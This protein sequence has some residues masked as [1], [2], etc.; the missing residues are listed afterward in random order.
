MHSTTGS[1]TPSSRSGFEVLDP[2]TPQLERD[3]FPPADTQ[4]STSE[5]VA[6]VGLS[7]RTAGG[8]NTP[9]K[10]WDFLL[11]KKNASGEVPA[12]RWEPWRQQD[13]R[14]GK[15][16]DN[17]IRKGYFLENLENFDAAFFGISPKEAELM[18]PHQ[19]LALELAWE[20]LENA[21]VDPKKLAG[22]DTAV[23]MGV[24]S[25]DY[26]RMLMEDLPTIEAW[27]GIG[28]AYHGIPNRI[29]YHLGLQGPSTAVDAA[30]ASSLIAIH[31]ARQAI[32]SGESTVAICGGVNVICA[33]GLTHML[34]KAGALT[35]EGVCRSF[36]DAACGYARGEGGAVVV[37]KR[38]SAAIEDND[39]ILAVMKSSASAQDGKTK[40]IMAP[41]SKAQE[42]V[43]RQ[44]LARAGNIDP[45]T[46]DYVEA[47]A[48]STSLGDPTEI[49]AIAQ[50]YGAGR[51]S[52]SPCYVGSIKPNVGHLEAAAGAIGFVKAVLSVQKGVVAPQTLLNKLNTKIDWASSGLE[53]AREQKAWPERD[54][55]R[56]AV[57]CYGYGGSVCHAILEQAPTRSHRLGRLQQIPSTGLS[58][59]SD[60]AVVLTLSAMQEKR[61]PAHAASLAH[62]LSSRDGMSEDLRAVARTLSQ[63]R[64]AHD[65]R[66]SFVIPINGHEDAVRSL[67]DFA[68]SRPDPWT[69]SNRVLDNAMQ[70][71]VVWVYSGHGAQWPNMGMELL[72]N[73]T[74]YYTLSSLDPIFQKEADFS[75]IEALETGNLGDSARVQILTYAVQIGLTALLKS[76]GVRP[77]AIIGHSVGEIAAAVAAGCLT[78]HE[79]AIVV[80]RRAKL[81]ARVQGQGA[82]ALVTS[83]FETAAQQLVGRVDI[84]AAIK[85]SPS[86]CV[87]S[88]TTQAVERYVE[89]LQKQSIKSWRVQTDIGFHSPMLG[90][91]VSALQQSLGQDINPQPAILPIYSTSASDARTTSLRGIEYW[92]K[93][94]VDPVWLVDA[95]DAAVEDGFRVFMEISTHP[96]VSHSI[97]ETLSARSIDECATFGIMKKDVSAEHSILNAIGQLH[98]LGG[99]VDFGALH[100]Q[101][102]WSTRV[103]NTPWV[104]KPYWKTISMGSRSAAQQ[105]DVDTHTVLGGVMEIAGSNTKVWTTTLDGSTKPYPLTHP[106]DGTEII[107]A[108]VYCNTFQ[109]A[110]GA[111]ILNNLE[112]RVPTPMA[113][114]KRE[115][116]IVVE[117]DEVR[118]A[119][120]LKEEITGT[121][122]VDHAWVQHSAARFTDTDMSSHQQTLSISAIRM[123][124]G[125]QL[126]NSFAWD[127]LQSIGVSGIAF[128]WAVLEHFGNDKEM[129]VKMDMDPSS[130]TLTWDAQSWAPF[131]DAA[132]SVGSSIFFKSV[133][134]RI[135]SGIDQIFFLSTD[136]PPK[137]GY[138]FIE[139]SSEG[140]NLKANISVLSEDGLLLTKI[141]GMRFSDV[142]AVSDKSKGVD[143]LVH[144]LTWVPPKFSETP[145]VMN[146]VVVVSAESPILDNYVNTLEI[147]AKRVVTVPSSANLAEPEI[148]TLLE[149]KNAIAIYL[150]GAVDSADEISKKAHA[151]TWETA[152]ILSILA[153]IPSAPK[154]FVIADSA[155]KSQSPTCLAQYPLYGFS[156]VAASEYPDVWGG[157]IDNEGPA[158]PLLPVKYVKEQ[159]VVRVQD[160]LPRVARLRPFA[161]DQHHNAQTKG[162]LPQPHGTYLVTGGFGDLGLEVLEFLVQ[163][164]ARRL[165][166]VSRRGLPP[167][168]DW[169]SATGSMG[170]VVKKIS[171]LESLGA[172]IHALA[173]DIGSPSASTEL[174]AALDRLSL[175]SVLG[176]IH[177]AGVSG[178]G[179][180]KDSTH[181]A[182]LEVMGPKIQGALSLHNVFPC[183]TLDFFVLFSSIGQ[184]LGTPGQSAYAASNAF[185]DGLATHRRSQGCNSIAIQWTAWRA[186]GLASDTALVDLEL[187]SK[188]VTDI[189]VEEGFQAWMHLSNIDT[190]HAVVTRTRILD[191]GEPLPCELI[192]DVVQ[193]RAAP[194]AVSATSA[195]APQVA[196]KPRA[197]PELKAHLNAEIKGCLSRVLHLGV[198][199]IEDRSAIAD[200]GVDSVMTVALRQQ[201]Q[202]AMGITVPPTLTWNHPTVGHL[203]E[204]F[205]EKVERRE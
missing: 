156:R 43:A 85:S 135:V 122:H 16:L 67:T 73:H 20:A 114:D 74:F 35:T 176:V 34:E 93:N 90:Q 79:G 22:S 60:T 76:Q 24:D 204:W 29:S 197:G 186:L 124:I 9:D 63:H 30:C 143:S 95:V 188:G 123:R 155:Y 205:Y 185:L 154:L 139:E 125:T 189:T 157:L 151:F 182:Y 48:T 142:E 46:I 7:C 177:A 190:D 66:V 99:Q 138:L 173:I 4:Q 75:V 201:L 14:N 40:G 58:P 53:V 108:A 65:Y 171:K 127:Y 98:T 92:T 86:T 17:I 126:P 19:R 172:T 64:A 134:M 5:D 28:T 71:G 6:I 70:K 160:G 179:Y 41:N 83:P 1:S 91:L 27:S 112:L 121:T 103:P 116:Q 104:H 128:P 18:D 136:I 2:H 23:Y 130:Q 119:S 117:G 54:L 181:S 194:A 96:I 161:K 88:G 81:Y 144:R 158:F 3:P 169:P 44:A 13:P 129:L 68:K 166:V 100:G 8:N 94:M 140:E 113:A 110:T 198:E 150:P 196:A 38:L 69:T 203:V 187:Q 133:R 141:K 31:L 200:L 26:S 102:P 118:L 89:R 192:A 174:S 175:P 115:L 82:M 120:R 159:S 162:L 77:Q 84:V 78:A 146:N 164:G 51:S 137:V 56:A 50:V 106:L 170:A 45:H 59:N 49:S 193:R 105:H 101:G 145:L 163:K 72:C 149:Q 57:C 111:T 107:P 87:V 12:Q 153:E 147:V 37:L 191:A 11:N 109:R 167:R 39:N 184:I 33:P 195:A 131:L 21:G 42:L 15:I 47:H 180:I 36:D 168:R 199:E 202:K 25:D 152:R 178:Y 80:S 148:K 132:T 61:L 32:V 52:D 165:V 10:L 97:F 183:G 62:W 55:R